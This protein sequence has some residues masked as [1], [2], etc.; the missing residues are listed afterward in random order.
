YDYMNDPANAE[1]VNKLIVEAVGKDVPADAVDRIRENFSVL[2]AAIS[3]EDF[4]RT[5]DALT[6]VNVL[7]P[8]P[9]VT[10]DQAILIK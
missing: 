5:V 3:P 8:A 1:A 9:A 6:A 10:Y 2:D 7:Q 4:Q